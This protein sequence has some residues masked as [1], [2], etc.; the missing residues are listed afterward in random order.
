MSDAI[1]TPFHKYFVGAIEGEPVVFAWN[2]FTVADAITT[3]QEEMLASRNGVSVLDIS[4]MNK[5]RISGPGA[6][7]ALD[8]M[9]SRKVSD[10]KD[11]TVRYVGWCAESGATI[12]DATLFRF[13]ATEYMIKGGL[14]QTEHVNRSV[15]D[16]RDAAYTRATEELAGLSVQGPRSYALLVAAGARNLENLRAFT[17]TDDALGGEPLYIS[18]TNYIGDLG[19]EIFC[20]PEQADAVWQALQATSVAV[21]PAG[22]DAIDLL[23]AQCG[24]VDPSADCAPAGSGNPE[25]ERTPAELGLGWLAELDRED[26]FIGKAALL[27]E[28]EQGQRW[29]FVSVELEDT[30]DT[31][32]YSLSGVQLYAEDGTDIGMISTGGFDYYLG[33]N[34]GIGTVRTGHG[35]VGSPVLVGDD[36][37]RAHFVKTPIF[38][39]E[40]R[41]Q[42][43]PSL[44]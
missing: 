16:G 24:F 8:Y 29:Q 43:P 13:S 28:K 40:R 5:Y 21:T 34:V 9:M 14:D 18:R 37:Q 12:G 3:T 17:F 44:A 4:P 33:K 25:F 10:M 1:E 6:G 26:D 2:G 30:S 36:K 42:T 22:Y 27:Q 41:T 31:G 38:S 20:K 32:I 23:R 7:A 19:Y 15:V 11:N 35:A 39:T